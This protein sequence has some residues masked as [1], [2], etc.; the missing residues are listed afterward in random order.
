MS[1]IYLPVEV[2]NR[3][4]MARAF[5]AV[6]LAANGNKVYIFEHTFFDRNGWLESGIYIG[7]NCF[8]TEVPYTKIY[9]D[10]MKR[11][12][13]DL[14]YLDEEG[15]I[16]PGNEDSQKKRL[17]CRINPND[18]DQKD[19]ILLW[20]KWQYQVM[21][22]EN[23]E[24]SIAITGS[25]N[26]DVLQEKY[27]KSLLEWDLNVT[28][29]KKDFIL[30]NTRFSIGNPKKG[31]DSVFDKNNPGSKLLSSEIMENHFIADNKMMMNMLE[32]SV[33]LAKKLPDEEI[34]IRPHPGEN[35]NIYEQVLKNYNNI[36]VIN[37]GGVESWIR[38]SKILIH[39]GCTTA[40]Q[41]AVAGKKVITYIPECIS[42][43]ENQFS[44]EI[45]NMVGDIVT[46]QDDL[47]SSIYKKDVV[48]SE[49]WR[50]TISVID[51]V[52]KISK[53]V[54]E[55]SIYQ[56]SY[57]YKY[58]IREKLTDYI[59]MISDLSYFPKN[60]NKF[61]YKRF[62]ELKDLLSVAGEVYKVKV[63]YKMITRGCYSVYV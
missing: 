45:P 22:E 39:N 63:N 6:K 35:L 25:P 32:M 37:S 29:G 57:K 15:G 9:Y 19:K 7:K 42:S 14:W 11:S 54:D 28:E 43:L 18:L 3:E 4:L 62:S 60:K 1:V 20:G 26:F 31:I 5:L 47:L 16:Y 61:D 23:P 55:Y 46:S 56:N 36:S 50:E 59:R 52:D 49:I 27:H 10:N 24:A 2:L 13:V 38:L 53:L 30:I 41:A 40:I 21:K 34:V 12:K 8:R 48:D 33:F 51:S 44:P 58:F 17:M